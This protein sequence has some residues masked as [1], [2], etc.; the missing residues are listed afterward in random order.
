MSSQSKKYSITYDNESNNTKNTQQ[1]G[2]L[3]LKEDRT[4]L[5]S[6]KEFNSVVDK[7]MIKDGNNMIKRIIETQDELSGQPVPVVGQDD[8][9]ISSYDELTKL[10]NDV[11]LSI[12][13][14][15][16]YK[17][18]C[19][20]SRLEDDSNTNTTIKKMFARKVNKFFSEHFFRG[21]INWNTYDDLT[22]DIKMDSTTII[23][24]RNSNVVYLA[25]FSE[26]EPESTKITHQL[27][28]LYSLAHYGVKSIT[29][30]LPYYPVGTMERIVG[31]GEI[32]TGYAFAQMLNNIPSATGK[33]N[34]II[35]DI[36]ALSSRFFFHTNLRPTIVSMLS[37]YLDYI[38]HKYPGAENNNI[39]VFPDDGAKKRFEKQMPKN[40]KTILCSKERKGEDRIIK[41]EE[42][43]ENIDLTGK[44][45]NLFIIDDLIQSG[46][47]S[48]ET[49]HGIKTSIKKLID[50]KGLTN[51]D[52]NS[53][54]FKYFTMITHL[55]APNAKKF[56]NFIKPVKM[57][58]EEE[59]CKAN[60]LDLVVG[61]I[62]KLITTNTRPLRGPY[63]INKMNEMDIT[64]HSLGNKIEIIDISEIL[65]DVLIRPKSTVYIAPN[66]MM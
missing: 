11:N 50:K 16:A 51:I 47:T 49:V 41:I 19:K 20:E 6:C 29:I 62:E 25:Y 34:L 57:M 15:G 61:D 14:P 32:P 2:A 53:N 43:I 55:V 23:N 10:D 18:F 35:F 52:I 13:S 37:Y 38:N 24:L 28:L 39:I 56:Y 59:K 12:D 42:G 30:V 46:G 54:K 31:E 9:S 66:I 4:I 65:H 7:I 8:I 48:K 45:N 27:M 44:T 17:K 40:F 63:L 60:K 33:N 26:D 22:P 5:L 21:F 1:G 58:T 64:D 3:V 36:H